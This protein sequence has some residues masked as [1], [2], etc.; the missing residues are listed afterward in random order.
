MRTSILIDYH[1][2]STPTLRYRELQLARQRLAGN[3]SPSDKG[4]SSIISAT[5]QTAESEDESEAES[6]ASASSALQWQ[7]DPE[8][9]TKVK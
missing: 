7:E 6:T 4:T 3:Q 5:T 8:F 2:T 9:Q 1:L